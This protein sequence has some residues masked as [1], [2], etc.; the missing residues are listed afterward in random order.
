MIAQP[1]CALGS[2]KSVNFAVC[3]SER[4]ERATQKK[5]NQVSIVKFMLLVLFIYATF[6]KIF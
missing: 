2:F 4:S 1:N 5:E 6:M 3:A